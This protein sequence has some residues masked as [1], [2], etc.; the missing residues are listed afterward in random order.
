MEIK[1]FKRYLLIFAGILAALFSGCLICRADDGLDPMFFDG[2][3]Y[4]QLAIIPGKTFEMTAAGSLICLLRV[5]PNRSRFE[6]IWRL[7][8]E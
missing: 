6:S 5:L 2:I 3:D 1:P 7:C 8:E 4:L